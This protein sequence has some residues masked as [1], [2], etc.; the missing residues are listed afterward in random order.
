MLRVVHSKVVSPSLGPVSGMRGAS[1]AR[2]SLTCKRAV[3]SDDAVLLLD[4]AGAVTGCN[5][6]FGKRVDT[7][8]GDLVG[9]RFTDPVLGLSQE[10]QHAIQR[11][12]AFGE[13]YV[14][15]DEDP[16]E[17]QTTLIPNNLS[18]S[19][20]RAQ[21]GGIAGVCIVRGGQR[22]RAEIEQ[23]LMKAQELALAGVL[24]AGTV[25]DLNNLLHLI[26]G[27]ARLLAAK[28]GEGLA[29]SSMHEIDQ[30][31]QRAS[32]IVAN[33]LCFGR[34][35]SLER[36]AVC[37]N[38]VVS[39]VC[40]MLRPMMRPEV[41]IT[42]ATD[43]GS[44]YV[45]GNVSQLE[46]IVANLCLNAR[47]AMPQGGTI[48][49]RLRAAD[50]AIWSG[51]VAEVNTPGRYAELVVGDN[52]EGMS[53]STLEHLFEPFY[54]TKRNGKGT[55]LGLAVTRTMVES[56]GGAIMVRSALGEGSVFHVLLPV[57]ALEQDASASSESQL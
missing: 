8:C 24:S 47:D 11:A 16:H 28:L 5:Q 40:N 18:V 43:V 9:T 12:L 19:P 6:A 23:Q 27:H 30:A 41:K 38:R 4:Q 53:E 10:A 36:S 51:V 34:S 31:V 22:G 55:G 29:E 3:D 48:E 35:G 17:Y 7:A 52:G 39:A 44:T 45:Y 1:G 14:G 33:V 13:A 46:Q 21:G 25:H 2:E 37:L 42:Y 15:R 20:L 26:H 57:E 50:A 54:T 56:H 49:V 32:G